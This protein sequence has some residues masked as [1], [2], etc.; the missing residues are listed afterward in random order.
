VLP[1]SL[2]S[3]LFWR[4]WFLSLGG[5]L[6]VV[7]L[8]FVVFFRFFLLVCPFSCSPCTTCCFVRYDVWVKFQFFSLYI[9]YFAIQ[10]EE[11]NFQKNCQKH[12]YAIAE[13]QLKDWC[14][15]N[16]ILLI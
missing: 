13:T 16:A 14:P 6:C 2:L 4:G 9:T 7:L 3:F 11:D 15:R 5:L 12:L 1:D 10:K 8:L